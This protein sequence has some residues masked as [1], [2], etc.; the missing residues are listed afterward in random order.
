M[1]NTEHFTIKEGRFKKT[2]RPAAFWVYA[3]ICLFDFIIAPSW[4][5][6]T[7][8]SYTELVPLIKNLKPEVQMVILQRKSWEPLTL[9]GGGLFHV[10][11]GVLLTGAAITRGMEKK[12]LA[13]K[14]ILTS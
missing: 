14:G 11:F 12:T 2:W 1:E 4:I 6:I 8:Q 10:S 9:Q 5:G 7:S 13:E 3:F